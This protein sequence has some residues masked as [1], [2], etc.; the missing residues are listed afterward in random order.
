MSTL[1]KSGNFRGGAAV[2]A[3]KEGCNRNS[4]GPC[5]ED[6][7][8]RRHLL[9]KTTALTLLTLLVFSSAAISAEKTYYFG[10]SDQRTNISFESHADFEIT[11]GNTNKLSGMAKVDWDKGTALV[12][13][14]V[15]VASLGTG[16]ELRDEHLR[17]EMW[18][19]AGTYPTIKFDAKK[20][21][22]VSRNEWEIQGT[23][24]MHGK[25]KNFAAKV[26]VRPIPTDVAT[27]AGLEAGE[28]IKVTTEFPVNLSD[29]GVSVPNKLAGK[30]DDTWNVSVSAF[31]STVMAG[32]KGMAACNPCN[33]CGGKKAMAACNPCNP[34]GGKK[35]MN[36]CNPCNPCGGKKKMNPCNPCNPCG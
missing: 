1:E 2:T 9:T 22:K 14:E 27:K 21:R 26:N 36:P 28:W 32:K 5:K 15:P 10:V 35:K 30:V 18:L 6:E 25:T 11:V 17:S 31:A 20:A 8:M 13:L 34:C 24:S 33:P 23:F 7:L 12:S 29:Y 3:A 19:D 4:L 16:I